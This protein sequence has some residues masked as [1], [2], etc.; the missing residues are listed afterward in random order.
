MTIAHMARI[1]GLGLVRVRR[2]YASP[3]RGAGQCPTCRLDMLRIRAHLAADASM[4]RSA[5]YV[6]QDG[7]EELGGTSDKVAA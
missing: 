4:P 7:T 1:K 6:R 5:A 3:V 2:A